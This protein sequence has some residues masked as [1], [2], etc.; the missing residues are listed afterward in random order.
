MAKVT[1][2]FVIRADRTVRVAKKPRIAADEVAIP[3]D[4]NFPAHWGSVLTERITLNVPDFT[5]EVIHEQA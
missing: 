1:V 2:Y 3:V 5:P 4:M